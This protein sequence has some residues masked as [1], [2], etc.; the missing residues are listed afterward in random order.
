MLIKLETKKKHAASSPKNRVA[1]LALFFY[2]YKRNTMLKLLFLTIPLYSHF[3]L[4]SKNN[5]IIF[6]QTYIVKLSSS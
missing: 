6:W 2:P 3:F 1:I 5:Q 4:I